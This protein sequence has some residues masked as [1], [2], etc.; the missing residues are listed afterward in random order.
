MLDRVD[1]RKV[2]GDTRPRNALVGAPPDLAAR[3][4]EVDADRI[5]RVRKNGQEAGESVLRL[6]EQMQR[7]GEITASVNEIAGKLVSPICTSSIF[8]TSLAPSTSFL[9]ASFE[10]ASSSS[11]S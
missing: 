2:L 1:L 9:P 8:F 5:V 6:A 11:G 3:R 7:I 10:S 4:A